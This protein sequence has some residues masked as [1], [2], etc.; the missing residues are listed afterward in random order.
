MN[1]NADYR[2]SKCSSNNNLMNKSKY[3]LT[4]RWAGTDQNQR[5]RAVKANKSQNPQLQIK[6][7]ESKKA[8]KSKHRKK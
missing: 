4:D 6:L 2:L 5:I 8:Q 7:A 1:P 3:K